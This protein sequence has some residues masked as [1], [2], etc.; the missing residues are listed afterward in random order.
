MLPL[1]QFVTN[2]LVFFNQFILIGWLTKVFFHTYSHLTTRSL[3]FWRHYSGLEIG[4]TPRTS[5]TKCRLFTLLPTRPSR[6]RFA[7]LYTWLLSLF[8]EGSYHVFTICPVGAQQPNKNTSK[9]CYLRAFIPKIHVRKV[10]RMLCSLKSGR[11]KRSKGLCLAATEEQARSSAH[12]E[13]W[14]S[15]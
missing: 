9:T 2:V 7:N 5:W 12:R 13:L 11:S 10:D 8:T 15:T 1:A 6:W 3:V 4:T 14:G